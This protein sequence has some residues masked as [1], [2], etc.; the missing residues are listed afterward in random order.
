MIALEQ[1][2]V[3]IGGFELRDVSF[4][5]PDGGYGVLM[6]RTGSGKTTLLEAICGLRPIRSGIVRLQ[7]RDVTRESPAK[8]GVGFVP[9]EGALFGHLTVRE[10]LEFALVVRHWSP[11]AIRTRVEELSAWLGLNPLLH[12]KPA[13]LSGG[14]TQRVALGRALSF[15]PQVLCLDEPLSALDDESRAEICS[16]LETIHQRTRVTVLHITHNRTEAERLAGTLLRI[17]DGT[18]QLQVP[19]ASR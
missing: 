19:P 17:H 3:G 8:R 15:Q 11:A 12:R 1:V 13:G 4:T 2:T 18:L 9:Q 16:V 6:G 10:H 7:G 5:I 14:E